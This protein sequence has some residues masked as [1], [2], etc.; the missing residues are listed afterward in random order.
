MLQ[1]VLGLEAA[2]IAAAFL[3]PTPTLAQRL[4]RAKRRIRDAGIGF[5]IPDQTAMPERLDAVLEA[6]YGAYSVSFPLTS[7]DQVRNS[8]AGESLFLAH[9]LA[10]LL[11]TDG[12]VLG[13]A[14]LLSLS[15]ARLEGGADAD[16]EYVPL[17]Q[18]DMSRWDE[19]LIVAGEKLL[20]RARACG[21]I[22]RFQ[23]EAAIHSV[24][25]ARRVTGTTD[26]PALATLYGALN[27]IAPSIGASVSLAAVLGEA[28][29]PAAGLA[30]LDQLDANVV[31]TF[32]P[33]WATRAHLLAGAGRVN[34]AR[35]AY[36]KAMSLTTD[37][38]TRRHLGRR[39]AALG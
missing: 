20:R 24:H 21:H 17:S 12:E 27:R 8:L 32:Q 10:M 14:A 9:T 39:N 15:I 2:T 13:L 35:A 33:A 26:W 6:I 18:Q 34:D 19:G 30:V 31:S 11:P 1:T 5:T 16:G 36:E 23:L 38:A 4:V 3:L 7:A 37:G 29:G 25:C 22:G 28:S